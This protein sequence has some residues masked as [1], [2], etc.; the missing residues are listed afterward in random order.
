M[1]SSNGSSPTANKTPHSRGDFSLL[2]SYSRWM[3]LVRFALVLW[4]INLCELFNAKYSLYS[5]VSKY[6]WSVNVLLILKISFFCTRL[7][8]FK[9]FYQTPIILFTI[10]YRSFV[11]IQFKCQT[12]LLDQGAASLSQSGLKIDGKKGVLHIFQNSSIT[13]TSL[14]DSLVSYPGPSRRGGS[15]LS[16]AMRSVYSTAPTDWTGRKGR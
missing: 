11:C 2:Q 9:Y 6:I 10:N 3:G 14:S 5:Y 12:V 7:K 15:H 1:P 16:V 4:H 13:G 8:G